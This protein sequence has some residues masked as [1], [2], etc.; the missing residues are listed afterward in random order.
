MNGFLGNP[1][2]SRNDSK[3]FVGSAFCTSM[4]RIAAF[5]S[6]SVMYIPSL[7]ASLRYNV[8]SMSTCTIWGINVLSISL[9]GV[10][11][12]VISAIFR[13]CSTSSFD[14]ISSSTTIAT[15]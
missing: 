10:M 3:L 6:S 15:L 8:S 7:E 13:R 11:P 12:D 2:C 5:N 4:L 9:D 14:I 1:C